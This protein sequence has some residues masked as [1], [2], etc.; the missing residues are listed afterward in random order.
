MCSFW[1]AE[2]LPATGLPAHAFLPTR[3]GNPDEGPSPTERERIL[4]SIRASFSNLPYVSEIVPIP[5]SAR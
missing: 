4:G 3:S 1:P 5:Q 2:G